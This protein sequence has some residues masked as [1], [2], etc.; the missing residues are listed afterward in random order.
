MSARDVSQIP[1]LGRS[2]VPQDQSLC[3]EALELQL[4]NPYTTT[5]QVH[6]LEPVR[7]KPPQ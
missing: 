5:T 2:H 7:E 6:A 1:D 4:L 3:P